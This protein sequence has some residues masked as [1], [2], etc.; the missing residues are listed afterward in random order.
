MSEGIEAIKEAN[1][2]RPDLII[3]DVPKATLDRFHEMVHSD[4]FKCAKSKGH[5]GFLLKY[6]IDYHDGKIPNGM[7]EVMNEIEL[8]NERLAELNVQPDEEKKVIKNVAGG[9]LNTAM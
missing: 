4:E 9:I 8:I 3:T 5:Y 6:L 7:P 2:A 1:R